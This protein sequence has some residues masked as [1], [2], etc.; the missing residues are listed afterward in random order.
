[1]KKITLL[2]ASVFSLAG[3]AQNLDPLQIDPT[4]NAVDLPANHYFIDTDIKKHL[5][6]T[7]GRVYIITETQIFRMIGNQLDNTFAP[8]T[9][10]GAVPN[11]PAIFQ[12]IILQP[13]GK[14]LVGGN[15]TKVDGVTRYKMARFNIDGSLD[16][17]FNAPFQN[18]NQYGVLEMHLLPSGKFLV[19]GD[20]SLSFGSSM[21]DNL[22]RI[23]ADGS[24]DTTFSVPVNYR[25][26]H[27]AIESAG[28]IIVSHNTNNSFYSD[29]NKVSRLTANGAMD[30]SFPTVTF[31]SLVGSE[32]WIDDI[33]I[34]PDSKILVSGRFT[35][36]LSTS[37]SGLARFNTNG[38]L[39][40]TFS[41][42]GQGFTAT[43]YVVCRVRDIELQPDGKILAGGD[44]THFNG[45]VAKDF[46]RLNANG[47]RDL[48]FPELTSFANVGNVKTITQLPDGKALISGMEGYIQKENPYIVRINADGT[49]DPTY[50][51][52]PKGFYKQS[53]SSVSKTPDGKLIAAGQFWT[54]NGE[55]HQ[56]VAKL[57]A[58]GSVDNTFASGVFSRDDS[59]L[60]ALGGAAVDADGKIYV[61]G[62]FIKFNGA[63]CGNVIRLNPDGS[64]DTTFPA[65]NPGSQPSFGGQGGISVVVPH[66]LG[67]IMVGG[68]FTNLNGSTAYGLAR[69]YANGASIGFGNGEYYAYV[70]D[71][72]FQ[73]DQKM[74]IA[75]SYNGGSI[76]RYLVSTMN[77]D[78]TFLPPSEITSGLAKQIA[79]Q[80]DGKILVAGE[81]TIGGVSK[82]LV[83][84]NDNG[85]IDTTFNFPLQT[86]D[87]YVNEV[88]V[89]PGGQLAVNFYDSS[90]YSNKLLLLNAD[91][92]LGSTNM[93]TVSWEARFTKLND[94]SVYMHGMKD[95]DGR[96][97]YGL[98]RLRVGENQYFMQGQNKL[99]SN[100]NGCQTI[101]DHI[102]RGTRHIHE[103]IDT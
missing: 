40:T 102:Y 29:D 59:T 38:T 90:I 24:L 91:G 78:P 64:K 92:S 10:V 96:Q 54:Y 7:E 55:H 63:N 27:L 62:N 18:M 97:L 44:F 95:Y 76:R 56:L 85:S 33:L 81:F 34:Q 58:D 71:I 74:L 45:A 3:W 36:A 15:F 25:W 100:N 103:F 37:S 14:L 23:N 9:F 26:N 99:D 68:S 87:N 42:G 1:M 16:T 28:T 61:A 94:G 66:P 93:P 65:V 35:G 20:T 11:E 75:L 70:S 51:N 84:L 86:A 89:L 60:P 5:V 67:G 22:V 101:S 4:F 83:R 21:Y 12:D 69:V 53:V 19:I 73:A 6:D 2:L 8:H 88:C 39:D 31:S 72:V 50:Q 46:I 48:T 13:D 77:S 79:L 57:N 17:T 80:D 82:S 30:P 49:W 43:Q 98:V 52:H 32:A 47:S 41:L